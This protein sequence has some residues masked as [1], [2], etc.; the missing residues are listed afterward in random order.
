MNLIILQNEFIKCSCDNDSRE[1]Q[2][3]RYRVVLEELVTNVE[4]SASKFSLNGVSNAFRQCLN[5][6]NRQQLI[7]NCSPQRSRQF[8][9]ITAIPHRNVQ[10]IEGPPR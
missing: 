6:L 3:E 7:F 10:K 1:E 4:L 8:G 9:G 5:V 2:N